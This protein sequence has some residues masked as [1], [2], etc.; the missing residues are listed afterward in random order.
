MSEPLE[1]LDPRY[2]WL[3]AAA[4]RIYAELDP[5]EQPHAL[6]LL[7]SSPDGEMLSTQV[8]GDSPDVLRLLVPDQPAALRQGET[9]M[10][11]NAVS[12]QPEAL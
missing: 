11:E 5:G 3:M 1:P 2:H 10:K 12:L 8:V 6:S 4:R 9:L 7:S